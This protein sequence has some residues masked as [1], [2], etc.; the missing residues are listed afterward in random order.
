VLVS[1]RLGRRGACAEDLLDALVGDVLLAVD[2][3]GV[4]PEEDLDAVPGS[5]GDLGR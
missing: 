2:A 3:L 4:D 1:D 5:L